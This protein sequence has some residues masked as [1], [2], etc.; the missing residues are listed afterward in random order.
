[1]VSVNSLVGNQPPSSFRNGGEGSTTM[2]SILSNNN[3]MDEISYMMK[4]ELNP[5]GSM[6]LAP[7]YQD[8]CKDEDLV[9]PLMKVRVGFNLLIME[10]GRAHV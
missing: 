8:G 9:W 7:Y 10:I 2:E 1:M 5:S 6:C 3:F 4:S